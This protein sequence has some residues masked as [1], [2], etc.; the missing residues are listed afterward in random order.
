MR[1]DL[2][3]FGLLYFANSSHAQSVAER[4]AQDCREH[5]VAIANENYL[6]AYEEEERKHPKGFASLF[7]F[8]WN[9]L[10][11]VPPQP[12]ADCLP[13]QPATLKKRIFKGIFK[14]AAKGVAKGTTTFW[15]EI[16]REN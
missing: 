5:G 6:I 3:F 12:P 7:H 14:G 15:K 13:Q 10:S 9:P 8:D 16:S 11:P 1:P 4:H 2:T